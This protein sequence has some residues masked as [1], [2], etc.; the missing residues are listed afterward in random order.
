[1]KNKGFTLIELLAIIVILAIIAVITVPQIL[2]V[3]E[4]SKKEGAKDSAY[5]Y[6]N[7]VHQY[8]LSEYAN[9]SELD[10]DGDYSIENGNITDGLNTFNIS[11]TG[12]IPE[13]GD[14]T[15]ENGE[16]VDGCID[17]G[18]YSVVIENGNVTETVNGSCYNISYFTY[19]NTAESNFTSKLPSPDSNWSYYL[20]EFEFQNK[21]VYGIY[22]TEY[23]DVADNNI[24][25]SL[26]SCQN[27]Y[28]ENYAEE[29]YSEFLECRQ[30]D[31]FKTYQVCGIYNNRTFCLRPGEKNLDY[32]YSILNSVFDNC[33]V[34]Y[35]NNY[36]CGDIMDLSAFIDEFG[37]PN[38]GF[39][40]IKK[41]MISGVEYYYPFCGTKK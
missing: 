14:V 38:I 37:Y 8:Y 16:I 4:N 10:M 25:L 26:E 33:E 19:D 22:H 31:K 41:R 20:K 11:P 32:N 21:Y 3:V 1:M 28:N 15:I 24:F 23:D 5:G 18:K 34:Y 29:E 6:K 12:S 9:D 36:L 13:S 40:S 30:V 35:G 17:Y 39:C 2:S 27:F 7:A